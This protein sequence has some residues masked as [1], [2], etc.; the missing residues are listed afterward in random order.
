MTGGPRIVGIRKEA[1]GAAE[2]MPESPAMAPEMFEAE[3]EVAP[4][5]WPAWLG[6]VAL[7]AWI[8]GMTALA[9]PWLERGSPVDIIEF[10]AALAAPPAFV[11]VLWLLIRGSS[12]SEA[13]RFGTTAAKMRAET[14]LLETRITT[15][16]DRIAQGRVDL[17]EQAEM[18]LAAGSAIARQVADAG[19]QAARLTEAAGTAHT[20]LAAL[21]AQLPEARIGADALS[22]ALESTGRTASERAEAL[23]GQVA[24]LATR[25]Q[26][27]K[28]LSE[29]AAQSLAEHIGEMERATGTAGEQ[30]GAVANE[31]SGAVDAMLGRTAQAVD[32]ARQGIA[33]QGEAM[34]A[35]I[36]ASQA[37]LDHA[38]RDTSEAL[39]ARVSAIEAAV[40]RIGERLGVQQ[41]A[42]QALLIHMESGLDSV[43]GRIGTVH[44]SAYERI[45]QLAAAVGALTGSSDAMT[46]ALRTGETAAEN[47]ISTTETLLTGLD[48]VARE[49]DETLPAS[50]ARL[51]AKITEGR[52]TVGEAKPELLAL[53]T[54]AESTRDAIAAIAD[55]LQ[56]QR[57]MV[58]GLSATLLD[59]IDAGEER[60]AAITRSMERDV[61]SI[62]HAADA[63]AQAAGHASERLAR[64]LEAISQAS[65]AVETQV[66]MVRN[67]RD[68]TERDQI[69][70]RAGMLS[71]ALNSAAIDITRALSTE[72]ADT[73]WA[74][75]LK[76]DRGVFT[77]R[78]VRLLG[79]SEARAI[80][81]HYDADQEFQHSVNRYVHDFE[82]MLRR[83]L[84]ERDG[85]MIAV[86]LMSSDMGKLY[87]ALGQAIDRRR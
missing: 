30:I 45:Q 20:D 42:G 62:A 27:A 15:L 78:A 40:N 60:S 49:M 25:A 26:E 70:R 79:G 12:A 17:A 16:N 5:R 50:L 58:D 22:A 2:L 64:Q 13:R 14:V 77:R 36:D 39:A 84:A 9:F 32:S 80:R 7:L 44:A 28:Q 1:Q 81:A 47:A 73:N 59:S 68:E 55:S 54:A 76:G 35:M 41:E 51:D 69:G 86:T 82:A 75:Y 23:D 31:M 53:V 74:A 71:E 67:E 38:S 85:G 21:L 8:G 56:E 63:A 6:S 52:R 29:G 34:L 11:A 10:A 19:E 48:A 57:K 46:E 61:A 18:L 24:A 87:A 3:E 66:E 37:A 4:A 43:D 65:R 72:V 83:V 33:A